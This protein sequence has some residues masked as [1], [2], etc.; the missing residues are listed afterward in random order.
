MKI[1]IMER[2]A[3]WILARD[4]GFV[5]RVRDP[6]AARS[7]I[8]KLPVAIICDA[9]KIAYLTN[10]RKDEYKDLFYVFSKFARIFSWQIKIGNALGIK[11]IRSSLK[12]LASHWEKAG[13]S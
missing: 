12:S 13:R 10:G 8:Y 9:L 1:L 4:S 3:T 7:R 5:A 6:F 11:Q 2:I